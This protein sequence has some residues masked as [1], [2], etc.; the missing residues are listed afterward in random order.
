MLGGCGVG[1]GTLTAHMINHADSTGRTPLHHASKMGHSRV[2]RQLH[3][4][5]AHLSTRDRQGKTP[6][7][8]AAYVVC[9]SIYFFPSF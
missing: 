9:C 1:C 5:G 3:V 6:L 7:Q 4:G 2:I 8:H